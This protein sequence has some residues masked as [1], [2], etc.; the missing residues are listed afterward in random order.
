MTESIYDVMEDFN[1]DPIGSMRKAADSF[2]KNPIIWIDPWDKKQEVIARIGLRGVF[3]LP[4]RERDVRLR[5]LQAMEATRETFGDKLRWIVLE[6]G[7][8]KTYKPTPLAIESLL[9]R[10]KGEFGVYVGSSEPENAEGLQDF[11]AFFSANNILGLIF[12]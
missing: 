12:Q 11:Q 3:Y 10:Y 6:G 5:M 4:A 1:D 2:E 7:K 8:V 9:D